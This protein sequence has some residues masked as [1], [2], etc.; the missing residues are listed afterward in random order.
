MSFFES[1]KF[2][3]VSHN[4]L[5]VVAGFLFWQHGAQKLFGWLGG[6]AVELMSMAGLAGTLEFFGGILILAGLF[7]R[8]VAFVLSGEMAVAYFTVHFPQGFWPIQ[9]GGELAA[10]Y[11][12]VFLLLATLGPGSFSLDAAL[13]LDGGDGDAAGAADG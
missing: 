12:F 1:A 11:A 3:N 6:D 7:T 8:P 10:L 9:N 5:R 13:G 4:A 2:R